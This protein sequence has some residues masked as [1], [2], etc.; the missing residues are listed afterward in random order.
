MKKSIFKKAILIA[1][2]LLGL[3]TFAQT[4]HTVSNVPGAE[5]DFTSVQDAIDAAASGDTI[6]VQPSSTSYGTGAIIDKGL[7]I[8]GRSHSKT[9][10]STQLNITLNENSSNTTIKGIEGFISES[11]INIAGTIN[12]LVITDCKSNIFLSDVNAKNNTLIQG[13]ILSSL[14][15]NNNTNTII[16][17][18]IFDIGA[19]L[20]F[21]DVS[22]AIVSN[23]IFYEFGNSH[24]S[25]TGTLTI[26]NSIF[27]TNSNNSGITEISISGNFQINNCLTYDYG[28][29]T[30][31]FVGDGS[32]TINEVN[33]T[34]LN[35][36]PLFTNVDTSGSVTSIGFNQFEPQTDDVSLAIGSPAIGAGEGGTDLGVFE[37]YNFSNL[38]IP[39]GFPSITIQNANSTV[40]KNA[41]L[42]VTISAQA[43]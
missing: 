24:S 14:S 7:T 33:N 2:S 38:G 28:G 35:T 10:A 25:S 16:S 19:P 9:N 32:S 8:I 30:L 23:N 5:A 3:Q 36:D 39:R 27:V 42:T 26:A 20:N 34:L 22:T 1:T 4:T 11:F 12:N 15:F 13:N 6:Y 40:A 31:M 41:N 29:G 37:G 21:T 18:N 17:N 43:N